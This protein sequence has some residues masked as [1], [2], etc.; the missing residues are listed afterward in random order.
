MVREIRQLEGREIRSFVTEL[1]VN[2]DGEMPTIE[3]YAA[4]FN[5]RSEDLGGGYGEFYEEI[6]P[7]AFAETIQVDDITANKNHNDDYLLGRNTAKPATLTLRED[8][9]GLLAVITPPDTTY[10]RDLLESMRRGDIQGM[11]FAF[12]TL[13]DEWRRVDGAHIR[14]LQKAKLYDV[15]VVAH[16]AYRDTTVGLRSFRAHLDV[17]AER[18]AS[19]KRQAEEAAATPPVE[20]VEQPVIP[21]QE[22]SE[23][24]EGGERATTPPVEGTELQ[25]GAPEDG[26]EERDAN[27]GDL[28][29]SEGSEGNQDTDPKPWQKDFQRR[30]REL[31]MM[32]ISG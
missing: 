12:R 7:G 17:E 18:A 23:G 6:D 24:D 32:E 20:G 1:R 22:G 21:P 13:S 30:N 19:E 11:S 10:A 4:V 31:E 9:K 2:G 29:P 8:D 26:S 5:V 28:T 14:T 3:G 25:S 15:S 27:G 16:P